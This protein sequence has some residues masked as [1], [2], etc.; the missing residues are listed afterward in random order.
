MTDYGK[1]LLCWVV[2]VSGALLISCSSC[3]REFIKVSSLDGE[4]WHLDRVAEVFWRSGINIDNQHLE[5]DMKHSTISLSD[6][7][8]YSKY[9]STPKPGDANAPPGNKAC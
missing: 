7:R 9:L 5:D 8:Y 1:H 3:P 2:A 6:F 4:P